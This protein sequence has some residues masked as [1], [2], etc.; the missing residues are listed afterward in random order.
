MTPPPSSPATRSSA[1]PP[2][3]RKPSALPAF[4]LSPSSRS[5]RGAVAVRTLLP[6]GPL[7]DQVSKLLATIPADAPLWD[8]AD[9]DLARASALWTLLT[10]TA[11]VRSTIAG[12]IMARKR[13]ELIPII[14][15]VISGRLACTPGTYWTTFRRVLQP[16]ALRERIAAL[17][18]D[19][20][21]LRMV[22]KGG[23]A[24]RSA[25]SGS[26]TRSG[27]RAYTRRSTV[28]SRMCSPRDHDTYRLVTRLRSTTR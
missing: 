9:L 8:A 3:T 5:T 6:G 25:S 2:T 11:G 28:H 20:P 14:D 22:T 26:G 7:A 27:H 18:P 17:K 16:T 13:P 12:K 21:V 19:Q 4:S 23:S 1:S 10:T 15:S 24:S